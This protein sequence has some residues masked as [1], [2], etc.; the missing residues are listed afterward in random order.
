MREWQWYEETEELLH[1][2]SRGEWNGLVSR[3]IEVYKHYKINEDVSD[4]QIEEALHGLLR[5]LQGYPPT[6]LVIAGPDGE[7]KT[8]DDMWIEPAWNVVEIQHIWDVHDGRND[9]MMVVG[10][11]IWSFQANSWIRDRNWGI[12]GNEGKRGPANEEDG[13]DRLCE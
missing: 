5:K 4:E 1:S 10:V 2:R 13:R 12:M 11:Y 3:A 6:W 9:G 8:P 7:I